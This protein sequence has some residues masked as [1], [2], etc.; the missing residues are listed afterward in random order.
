MEAFV[1]RMIEEHKTLVER[2]RKLENFIYSNPKSKELNRADFANMCIQLK[3]MRVY[4]EALAARLG[5]LGICVT[6]EG[7]YFAQL[8]FPEAEE[9]NKEGNKDNG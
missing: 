2:L 9:E 4:E 5:N 6:E 8:V 7:E 3:A 1:E